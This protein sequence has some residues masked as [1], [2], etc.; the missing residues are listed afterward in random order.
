M[1]KTGQDVQHQQQTIEQI[2]STLFE[3]VQE[4][5]K[6]PE[7]RLHNVMDHEEHVT[8]TIDKNTHAQCASISALID[9]QADIRKFLEGLAN[10]LD[11]PQETSNTAQSEISTNVLLEIGDLKTKV[12]QLTEQSTKHDGDLSFLT[13]L[14]E[15]VDLIEDQVA[16]QAT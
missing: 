12:L 3:D 7:E 14:S 9:E 11:Q 8:K 1:Q 10:R 5:V 16:L 6:S 2:K 4:R 15:Q 13:R